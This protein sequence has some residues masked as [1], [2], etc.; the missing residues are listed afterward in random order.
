MSFHLPSMGRS[1]RAKRGSGGDVERSQDCIQDA[2][3][4]GEDLV[5]P[6]TKHAIAAP[7]KKPRPGRVVGAR[8]CFAVLTS[9]ELY[10]QASAFAGK[11]GDVGTDVCLSAE[12]KTLRTQEAKR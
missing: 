10:D 4:I 7:L 8:I 11:V 1:I 2:I 5:V 6:E 9:V 12:V 3:A